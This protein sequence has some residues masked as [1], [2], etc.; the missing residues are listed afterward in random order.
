MGAVRKYR[1]ESVSNTR[2]LTVESNKIYNMDLLKYSRRG[3]FSH[4]YYLLSF[5][6]SCTTNAPELVYFT[7]FIRF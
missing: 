4:V 1:D 2:C 3:P 6:L 7:I 5:K